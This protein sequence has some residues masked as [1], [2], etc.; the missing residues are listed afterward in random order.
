MQGTILINWLDLVYLRK[1]DFTQVQGKLVVQD[2]GFV[3]FEPKVWGS[4]Q[5]EK[6][7]DD[8]EAA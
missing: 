4:P 1:P 7:D 6:E 2:D 5:V 8:P 3:R